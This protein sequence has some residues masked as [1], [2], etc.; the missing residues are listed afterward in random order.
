MNKNILSIGGISLV[1]ALI[2][3]GVWWLSTQTPAQ[4]PA[5]EP[6]VAEATTTPEIAPEKND[7]VATSTPKEADSAVAPVTKEEDDSDVVTSDSPSGLYRVTITNG[8]TFDT[9][10]GYMHGG[11]TLKVQ[12]TQTGEVYLQSRIEDLS[13]IE[14]MSF[15][16]SSAPTAH[17]TADN[18]LVFIWRF[19]DGGYSSER[20]SEFN[21]Q[22]KTHTFLAGLIYGEGCT[23]VQ[24]G[25]DEPSL[26]IVK[27]NAEYR[28]GYEGTG[29]K[30]DRSG[31]DVYTLNDDGKSYDFLFSAATEADLIGKHLEPPQ[32]IEEMFLKELNEM[33]H[34]E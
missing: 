7:V 12:N 5:E 3:G 33:L 4:N 22:T 29:S 24:I 17:W 2:I 27:T 34:L 20:Y 21:L 11:C 32:V 26:L 8:D 14:G 31:Y 30:R 13:N 6:V 10:C 15:A 1:C 28:C 23:R 9:Q 19:G 16:R 25:A 18:R